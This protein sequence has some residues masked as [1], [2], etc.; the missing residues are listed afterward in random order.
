MQ[1]EYI[2][3]TFK[4]VNTSF[5]FEHKFDKHCTMRTFIEYTKTN[6]FNEWCDVLPQHTVDIEILDT[7]TSM[8]EHLK[9][10][11]EPH[12]GIT[13]LEK[14]GTE[15]IHNVAFYGRPVI[16]EVEE[17]PPTQVAEEEPVVDNDDDESLQ[18]EEPP[19]EL[20]L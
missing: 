9:P 17:Q 15:G 12:H 6:M 13:L 18:Q 3:F 4:L 16:Y 10:A 5:K 1:E 8:H 20:T 19:I 11:I 7:S 2:T 14:Y